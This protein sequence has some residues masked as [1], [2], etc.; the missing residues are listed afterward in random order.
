MSSRDEG[1]AKKQNVIMLE[2]TFESYVNGVIGEL[3]DHVNVILP[4]FERL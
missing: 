1:A 3:A 2:M 4:P